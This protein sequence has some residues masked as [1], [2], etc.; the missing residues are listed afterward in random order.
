MPATAQDRP[1]SVLVLDEHRD[2]ADSLSEVLAL[3]GFDARVAT[4]PLDA[5]RLG[6]AARPDAV[7]MEVRWPTADGYAL[8][9]AICRL[10]GSPPLLI[11]L[12]WSDGYAGHSRAA[13]FDGHFV[14]PI[15]PARLLRILGR[16][17]RRA[18]RGAMLATAGSHGGSRPG[19]VRA[20]EVR[21]PRPM[22][23]SG[24]E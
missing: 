18:A 4:H 20:F 22:P 12:T 13:G 5:L 19:L 11:A 9:R 15:D 2:S 14:K 23:Q 8:A 21:H 16:A 7:V 6:A 1:Y 10:A 3:H 24:R 17:R